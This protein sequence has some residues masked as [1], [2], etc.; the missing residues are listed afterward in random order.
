MRCHVKRFSFI[1]FLVFFTAPFAGTTHA[2]H[3]VGIGTTAPGVS[4][5]VGSMKDAVRLPSG[6]TA[7]RPT[8][9]ANGDIRY[10]STSNTV[11]A[12]VNGAWTTWGSPGSAGVTTGGACTPEGT[13]GYD[14]TA[15]TPVYCSSS[16]TWTSMGGGDA[17]TVCGMRNAACGAGAVNGY[18]GAGGGSNSPAGGVKCKGNTLTLTGC[19]AGYLPTGITGCPAG[20]TG[21]WTYTTNGPAFWA[22][23]EI[24]CVHN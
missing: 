2:A 14:M 16:L 23:Y 6:T 8:T 10:N 3:W 11:E 24:F 18:D 22:V 9:P 21:G 17:G 5:D 15:H 4:L 7:E 1:A 13:F 19:T 12:Y 20:Y